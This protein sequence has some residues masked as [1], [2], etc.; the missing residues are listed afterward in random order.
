[1]E[2]GSWYDCRGPWILVLWSSDPSLKQ[3]WRLAFHRYYYTELE[4]AALNSID[5][6]SNWIA[7]NLI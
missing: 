7:L 4:C 5:L 3:N 2:E 1:M 6:E